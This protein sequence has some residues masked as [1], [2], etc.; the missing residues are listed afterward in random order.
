MSRRMQYSQPRVPQ[1]DFLVVAKR[2]ER[3]CDVSGLMETV[4]GAD[5][6]GQLTCSRTMVGMHVRVDD[7]RDP[8]A[9]AFRECRVGLDIVGARIDDRTFAECA[10][11]KE[12]RR[13]S[14]VVIVE[15]AEN[16]DAITSRLPLRSTVLSRPL[17]KHS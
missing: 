14:K 11:A 13:T 16:H 2:R 9:F 5:Q 4:S 10:A 15:G 12:V 1:L 8:H 7:M 17:R 6:R 3:E